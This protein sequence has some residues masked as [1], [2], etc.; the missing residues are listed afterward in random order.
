MRSL[1]EVI[2]AA[3]TSDRPPFGRRYGE[4]TP[5]QWANCDQPPCKPLRRRSYD[6]L[7]AVGRPV[8]ALPNAW[9]ARRSY[10]RLRRRYG[11]R[12]FQC[13]AW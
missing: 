7:L 2:G 6:G 9:G 12:V 11:G 3:A 13:R 8:A 5:R 4:E 10:D 1:G